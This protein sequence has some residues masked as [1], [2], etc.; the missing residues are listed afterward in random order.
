MILLHLCFSGYIKEYLCLVPH[1][2]K[3]SFRETADVLHRS[4]T[5]KEDFSGYRAASAWNA[6]GMYAANLL[7]QPWRKEY[8]E[9]KLFCGFYKHEIEANL[10]GAE[11]MLQAMGYKHAGQTIM[12]LDGPIDPDRVS[13]VSRDSLMAF[14]ECQLL[15]NIWEEVSYC[16]NCSWLEVLEFRENHVGTAENAAKGL[17]YHFHQRQYQEQQQLAAYHQGTA[18]DTYGTT[19]RFHQPTGACMYSQIQ[20][21]H[22]VP[23]MGYYNYPPFPTGPPHAYT[24]PPQ[25]SETQ[26]IYSATE[27]ASSV[28]VPRNVRNHGSTQN[29]KSVALRKSNE[30]Q[31]DSYRQEVQQPHPCNYNTSPQK[32]HCQPLTSSKAKE[33]GTGTFESWDYVFRNLESQGYS[34][35]LGERPNILSPSPERMTG[36][37]VSLRNHLEDVRDSFATTSSKCSTNISAMN[38]KASIRTLPRETRKY[39]D[40]TDRSSS[41]AGV[42]YLSTTLDH[43][44]LQ[45][46][47]NFYRLMPKS[48]DS[49]PPEQNLVLQ[50]SSIKEERQGSS[51]NTAPDYSHKLSD[52]ADKH[53]W[54]CVTCTFLNVPSRDICEMCGKSKVRGPE[55]RPLASGG[56][57]C[58]QCT[59]VNE[60][61]VG[62]CEACG[63]SLKDSPTYI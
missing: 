17:V 43:K 4:A 34:K 16:F 10:A 48:S 28:V 12:V 45:D 61:G 15:K 49:S 32:G 9:M 13:N 50:D 1:D 46:S 52:A 41:L 5:Q 27:S 21:L 51:E 59:L 2:R 37:S 47:T 60:K 23:H 39:I 58:P 38:N 35:D 63:A 42:H 53:K 14:V 24:L 56:R 54:E 31:Q 26:Q 55:V 18:M 44:H 40:E 29:Q 57:E 19:A 3:F 7:A 11:M 30:R 22:P 36:N 33:D 8:R 62:T 20:P 6:I 25:P